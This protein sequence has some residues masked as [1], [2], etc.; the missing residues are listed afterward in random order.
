MKIGG[1]GT[2]VVAVKRADGRGSQR[3]VQ[4]AVENLM[5]NAD[6]LLLV[7]VMPTI[8]YIPTP[9]G[10]SIPVK[11]LD[12]SVV[13]MYINDAKAK[14]EEIFRMFKFQYGTNKIKTLLLE[15]ENAAF[16]LL[17]YVTD[18]RTTSLVLG[19][20]SASY[21]SRKTKDSELP[22]VV[23]KHAPDTCNIY[24]VSANK[25]ISNS[26]S[27]MLTAERNLVSHGISKQESSLSSSSAESKYGSCLSDENHPLSQEHTQRFSSVYSSP[28]SKKSDQIAEDTISDTLRTSGCQHK[29]SPCSGQCD[30]QAEIEQ[31]QLKL[32]NTINM[33]HKAC[34]DLGRAQSEVHLISSECIDEAQKV[35]ATHQRVENHRKMAAIDKEKYLEAEKEIE[36]AKNLLVK[37]KYERQVAELKAHK[38][39]LEKQKIVAALLSNDIRYR[40]YSRDEIQM[41]TGSFSENKMIGE[42]AYGKVYK[43]SLD[44]TSVAIKVL[45]PDGPDRKEEFLREVE[46][47]SRLRHPHIVLLLGACPDNG[48]LVYEY[49]ENGSL[50]DH[51]FRRKGRTPLPLSSR[52]RIAFEVACGLAFLHST[53]PDPIVHRDLKPGNILLD[54]YRVSKIS[55]VGLSKII[56]DAVADGITVYRDTV[57]AGTLHYV[58]PEYARTG[59]LRPKSDLYSFGVIAL[60]LLSARRPNGIITKFENAISSGSLSDLLDKSVADWPLTEAHQLAE[61][62]LKCCKLRCRDRPDLETEVLPTLKRLA[63]FADSRNAEDRSHFHA[64]KHFYCPILQEI[65][66]NP[67]I[68][69]DGFTYEHEAMKAWLYEHDIS[70]TTKQS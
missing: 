49:M 55:D 4:W 31:M 62:A 68:A 11:E 66:H 3:A 12:A 21:F 54:K 25:I 29:S 20:C 40:K 8:T 28:V 10:G 44:H 42:G 19:S 1:G 51:I 52:F 61:I 2:V 57:V 15:G 6:C 60:Q 33:Y 59:T 39:S 16:M 64:P 63:E 58:D 18:S 70:P 36:K 23:L 32:E 24:V 9:S 22:S 26:L 5:P 46:V 27:H 38:G 7:H 13:E 30:I 41:A 65:M 48:S 45:R 69:A 50:E 56:S 67:H 14:C 47:L 17:R 35:N 37:E 53:K 34:A 43:C